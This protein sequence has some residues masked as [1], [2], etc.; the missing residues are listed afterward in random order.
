LL[1]LLF[2]RL[3]D[4]LNKMGALFVRG[5][6]GGLVLRLLLLGVVEDRDALVGVVEDTPDHLHADDLGRARARLGLGLGLLDRLLLFR[7]GCFLLG[8]GL[9]FLLAA[10]LLAGGFFFVFLFAFAFA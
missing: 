7:W 3:L 10:F 8:F 2:D 9:V 4:R 6:L 5:Q 1:L